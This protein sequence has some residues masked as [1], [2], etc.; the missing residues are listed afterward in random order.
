MGK[1][2]LHEERD[3]HDEGSVAGL[4]GENDLLGAVGMFGH[5][6]FETRFRRDQ[7]LYRPPLS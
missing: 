7:W 6:E 3:L 4:E 2:D 5:V 1:W